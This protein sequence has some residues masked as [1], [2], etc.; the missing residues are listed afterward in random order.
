M[1]IR[2]TWKRYD[3]GWQ[4]TLMYIALG[5]LIAI[6]FNSGLGLVFG[7]D[8]P[9][10]AVFSNS[11]VPTFEKGDM[12]IVKGTDSP[13]IGDV[14][15][16]DSPGYNYPIIHRIIDINENGMLTKGDHNPVKDPWT[17]SQENVHGKAILKLPYLGW[18]KV[19]LFEGLGL[20]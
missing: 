4:G 6:I 13:E 14:I 16:F 1:G 8:T 7:T 9:I 20:V 18:V 5:F 17:I 15:V 19:G 2:E 3:K 12:I 10:V 11:M